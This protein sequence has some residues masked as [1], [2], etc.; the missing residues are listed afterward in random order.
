M[1]APV[2]LDDQVKEAL[3]IP[4]REELLGTFEAIEFSAWVDSKASRSSV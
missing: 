2:D 4:M 1:T 3:R